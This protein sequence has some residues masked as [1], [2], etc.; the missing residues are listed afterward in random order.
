[1]NSTGSARDLSQSRDQALQALL[2]S[3]S[4]KDGSS[5][6]DVAR[7][8]S[9]KL[10]ELVGGVSDPGQPRNE[11]GELV[12]EEGLPIIDVTEP[13][14]DD[15]IN[16]VSGNL[17]TAD[18]SD[19]VPLA[20]LPD[21]ERDRRRI[22]RDRILDMLENEE[23]SENTRSES[24][25]RTE[26]VHSK[27][28]QLKAAREMQ[29]KMGKA[30]LRNMA[31]ARA[32]EEEKLRSEAPLPPT[33]V[34]DETKVRKV[35]KS[36]SFAQ[37]PTDGTGEPKD[38]TLIREK[39]AKIDWGDVAPARLRSDNKSK[40]MT[41]AQM[42]SLPMKLDVVERTPSAPSL[43][44]DPMVTAVDSDDESI[45][46]SPISENESALD[47]TVG[48]RNVPELDSGDDE[49]D[50]E[51]PSDE[52]EAFDIDDALHH[53]EVALAYYEKRNV[54]GSDAATALTSHSH[55]G[56][57]D[58]DQPEVPLDATLSSSRPKPSVSRFKAAHIA[59]TQSTSLGNSVL[60]A[61][62]FQTVQRAVRIGRL[63][64]D[65]LVGGEEGESASEPEDETM[66]EVLE[67]LKKGE[68]LNIGPDASPS[69]ASKSLA[70]VSRPSNIPLVVPEIASPTPTTVNG[71]ASKFKLNRTPQRP[72]E[73]VDSTTST[74]VST[75]GRSSPKLPTTRSDGTE[76]LSTPPLPPSPALNSQTQFSMIVESPSFPPPVRSSPSTFD[77]QGNAAPA[78]KGMQ[79]TT[80]LALSLR[81]LVA[82]STRTFFQPD[83]YYQSLEPAHALVFGYGHLTW[84]WLTPQPIRSIVYPA[85]NV[86]IYWFLKVTGLDN[87]WPSLI[88]RI[89]SSKLCRA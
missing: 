74:P 39:E 15:Q 66:K 29:K 13:I 49:S 48:T 28:E 31:E 59:S 57:D 34:D 8:L 19:L 61:S 70:S 71:K 44:K 76:Y 33:P 75:A 23:A 51:I 52:G 69:R 40:P 3:L 77:S 4:S 32:K 46:G 73:P 54:V 80:I 78:R 47:N 87:V 63:E 17:V 11:Q 38:R 85:L 65:H 41:K 2:G 45:P 67:L 72:V 20:S 82:L 9:E 14:I 30:L 58:W 79:P 24:S 26:D 21:L 6:A 86:P 50:D 18:A 88:V 83:E 55:E 56:E 1:M 81:I 27:V 60:P 7:K 84:E 42:N 64:G 37:L 10:D 68:V 12:N 43:F 25:L 36:V 62:G 5:S 16:G 22:E 89:H 35:K 53:R